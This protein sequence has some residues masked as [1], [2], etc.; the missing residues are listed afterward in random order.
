MIELIELVN[1]AA[2]M[3]KLTQIHQYSENVD[4]TQYILHTDRMYIPAI[5]FEYT[6]HLCHMRLSTS[7]VFASRG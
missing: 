4:H 5:K 3:R 2:G 7:I 6:M 1:L